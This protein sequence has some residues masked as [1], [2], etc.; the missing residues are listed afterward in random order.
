MPISPEHRSGILHAKELALDRFRKILQ[1]P[2][3]LPI[4]KWV[5]ENRILTTD[6][7]SLPGPIDHDLTPYVRGVFEALQDPNIHTVVLQWA[8]QTAKTTQLLSYLAWI[9]V[10]DPGP[11][12]IALP[13]LSLVQAFSRDRLDPMIRATPAVRARVSEVRSNASDNTIFRKRIVGGAINLVSAGSEAGLIS[14]P[15]KYLIAD[16][17]DQWDVGADADA[18]DRA[19]QRTRSFP[20]RKIIFTSTPTIEDSSRIEALFRNS[21]QRH[22]YAPCP[23]CKTL[24]TW[25]WEEHVKWDEHD[26]ATARIECASC[27]HHLTEAERLNATLNGQWQAHEKMPGVAG[28]YLPAMY[29]SFVST[30][31]LAQLWL[32]GNKIPDRCRAFKNEQLAL[33][34][35]LELPKAQSLA[36]EEGAK[37][38]AFDTLPATAH[39]LLAA[40]DVQGDRV[41]TSIAAFSHDGAVVHVLDHI[42][43]HGR[44]DNEIVW[45]QLDAIRDNYYATT[46]DGRHLAIAA[47][48]VDC[49]FKTEI[50]E[51][52]CRQRDF[53]FA[54]KGTE[55]GL[56]KPL[57]PSTR[58]IRGH[59]ARF[60]PA[61]TSEAKLRLMD[62]LHSLTPVLFFKT[63]LS[64]E[65]F[66][67]LTSE[68]LDTKY[69][70]GNVKRQ[71]KR[72]QGKL[73]ETLDCFVYL[74]CL[75]EMLSL[76]AGN[77]RQRLNK[78][79][80]KAGSSVA[81]K[82][83]PE[84]VVINKHGEPEPPPEPPKKKKKFNV[85]SSLVGRLL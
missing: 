59:R 60:I 1:P 71:W 77:A 58:L 16:E 48:A 62:R 76:Q 8:S 54:I 19:I 29:S 49:G 72:H 53:T 7:S 78:R 32:D 28:F 79:S 12:L 43:S 20:D 33:T 40:T 81:P 31:E 34:Y 42:V 74:L 55:G 10:N 50:V 21:D 52:Y 73:A 23:S 82:P 36:A 25:N 65:Y 63:G 38:P 64:D 5:E 85:R 45:E 83:K 57:V 22:Y 14:R 30:N 37:F 18:V 2:S 51:R 35:R 24:D 11:V 70:R 17:I 4:D 61:N 80:E 6:D 9:I 27:G 66:D 67:Q 46:E 68:Y 56:G 47:D 75:D 84:P 3:P 13:S 44:P 69:V 41:E 26:A 15:I 39:Y